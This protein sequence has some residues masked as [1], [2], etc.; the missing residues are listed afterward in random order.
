MLLNIEGLYKS[1]N[2]MVVLNDINFGVDFGEVVSL[3]GQSGAGK[4]T[5]MRCVAGLEKC[6]RGTIEINGRC[7]CAA[8]GKTMNYAGKNELAEIR[9]DIGMVFQSYHLFPH[10]TVIENVTLALVEVYKMSKSEA[11][12]AAVKM[13]E[14]LGLGDKANNKPSE[15]SGGQKQR[16]AIARSCVTNPKLL[17][18]DEPTAA[19]DSALVN[20]I[21]KIIR[22]FAKEDGMGIFII[23]HDERF[24]RDVSDRILFIEKGKITRELTSEEYRSVIRD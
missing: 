5:V 23:S 14:S 9:K 22:S 12:L 2:D 20:E 19:L 7:V 13:L 8:N 18:F 17:C 3:V 6:D 21:V 10:L 24:V 1:F 15:L 16:V 4:T 11:N